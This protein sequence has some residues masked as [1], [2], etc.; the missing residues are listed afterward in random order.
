[1]AVAPAGLL[2]CLGV[3]LVGGA[4]MHHANAFVPLF[5]PTFPVPSNHL[6]PKP[7]RHHRNKQT[8]DYELCIGN[9]VGGRVNDGVLRR[10]GF[11]FRTDVLVD[12]DIANEGACVSTCL[13]AC[14]GVL[15]RRVGR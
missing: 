6:E 4:D 9:G 8:G 7:V 3:M 12:E 14:L 15:R 13:S 1:M 10:A 5:L 11:S 2:A